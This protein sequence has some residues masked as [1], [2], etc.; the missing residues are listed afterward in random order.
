MKHTNCPT[1]EELK[2][3]KEAK[4]KAVSTNQIITK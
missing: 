4:Q 1:V 2:A 3:I